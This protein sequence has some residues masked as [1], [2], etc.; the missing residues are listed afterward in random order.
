MPPTAGTDD[1]GREVLD[2]QAKKMRDANFNARQVTRKMLKDCN[3]V[4][5]KAFDT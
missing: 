4:R 1:D 5:E 3:I 2:T